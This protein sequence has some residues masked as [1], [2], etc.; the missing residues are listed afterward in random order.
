MAELT[1]YD[2]EKLDQYKKFLDDRKNRGKKKKEKTS[3]STKELARQLIYRK[4][5][6]EALSSLRAEQRET[7]MSNIRKKTEKARGDNM[8]SKIPDILTKS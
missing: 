7:A 4:D 6:Q 1:A 8:Y 2:K 5:P 3:E